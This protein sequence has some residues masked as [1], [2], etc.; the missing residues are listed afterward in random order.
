MDSS[1]YFWQS[2][3]NGNESLQSSVATTNF[4][5]HVGTSQQQEVYQL[6]CIMQIQ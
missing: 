6:L 2:N 1:A 3:E 5:Q 4:I